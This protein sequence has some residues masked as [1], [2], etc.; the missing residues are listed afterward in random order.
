MSFLKRNRVA[1]GVRATLSSTTSTSVLPTRTGS[2]RNAGRFAV[3]RKP[4]KASR[5]E[6]RPRVSRGI[7]PGHGSC[8]VVAVIAAKGRIMSTNDICASKAR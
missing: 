1:K 2:M 4:A 3:T 8:R 5:P 7:K 6:A